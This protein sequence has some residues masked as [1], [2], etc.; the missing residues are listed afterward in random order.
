ME[1]NI[2]TLKQNLC[3][4]ISSVLL[5]FS[6]HENSI[7]FLTLSSPWITTNTFA[8]FKPFH[9]Q[10]LHLRVT[11]L[12]FTIILLQLE[13]NVSATVTILLVWYYLFFAWLP[14]SIIQ[15]VLGFN[16][17]ERLELPSRL[18]MR[19]VSTHYHK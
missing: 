15:F 12:E 18:M 9:S 17:R 8:L 1:N 10:I 7:H 4:P 3:V 13:S 16:C 11:H 2:E 19:Y 14:G 5:H 6:G